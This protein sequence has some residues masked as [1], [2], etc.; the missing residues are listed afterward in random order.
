M[1]RVTH[2]RDLDGVSLVHVAIATGRTHQIR[3]QCSSRGH[4]LLGDELYG[5]KKSFGPPSDDQRERLIALHARLLK[6]W[7]H[8]AAGYITVTA[9]LPEYWHEAGVELSGVESRL[10][11]T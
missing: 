4:P 1:T 9:P 5:S 3:V 11:L 7:H 8:A 2:A 10:R 6:F